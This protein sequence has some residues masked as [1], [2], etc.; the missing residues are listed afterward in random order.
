MET[1][2]KATFHKSCNCH[3][4]RLGRQHFDRNLNERKL[5]RKSKKQLLDYRLKGSEDVE[6]HPISSPFTD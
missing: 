1:S 2:T 3:M 4:C 5:R 6:I